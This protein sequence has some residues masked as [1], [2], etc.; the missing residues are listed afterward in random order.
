MLDERLLDGNGNPVRCCDDCGHLKAMHHIACS[1]SGH[2]DG[3]CGAYRCPCSLVYFTFGQPIAKL[4][5]P[6]EETISSALGVFEGVPPPV[7][8]PIG[9]LHELVAAV[10]CTQHE[11]GHA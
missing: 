7:I 11:G 2:P 8:T 4:D 9:N 1:K 6:P 5:L 3:G 10:C